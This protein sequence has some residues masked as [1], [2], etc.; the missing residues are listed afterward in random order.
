MKEIYTMLGISRQNVSQ[1]LQRIRA[2]T[3]AADMVVRVAKDI[4]KQHP[5]MGCRKIYLKAFQQ[6]PLGRDQCE[7]ILLSSGF[8]VEFPP[9]FRRTTYS[10]GKLYY[11]NRI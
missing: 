5:K 9:N 10:I 3:T 2:K 11:P 6:L 7:Q 1:C 4:R 8:R